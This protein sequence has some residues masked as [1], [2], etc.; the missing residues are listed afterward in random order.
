MGHSLFEECKVD[1]WMDFVSQH[2]ELP[3][4][5]WVHPVLGYSEF[6]SSVYTKAVQET[7]K[8]LN[9]MDKYL[10]SHTYLV[11]DE[12]TLADIVAF[13]ALMYPMRLVIGPEYRQMYN[14]LENWFRTVADHP[15]VKSVVGD[16]VLCDEEV[17]AP[18]NDSIE[19]PLI[20]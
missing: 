19:V 15:S 14:F 2:L 6:N 3:V 20:P 5:L 10:G 11:G 7:H 12:L 4:T 13:A 1:S 18:G 16:T 9:I 8:C 17:L